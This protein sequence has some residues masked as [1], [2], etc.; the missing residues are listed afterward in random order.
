MLV[1]NNNNKHNTKINTSKILLIKIY[2]IFI[3]THNYY[4]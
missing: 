2:T 4:K 1:T 3:N